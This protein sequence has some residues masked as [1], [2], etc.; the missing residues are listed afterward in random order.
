MA[1][2]TKN[3]TSSISSSLSG[4]ISN[5]SSTDTNELWLENRYSSLMTISQQSNFGV[6][7]SY[8]R[9]Q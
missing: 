2:H 5:Q 8:L 7:A 6:I 1:M 4:K 9:L 3:I